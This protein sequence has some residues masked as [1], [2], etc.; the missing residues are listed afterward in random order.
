MNKIIVIVGPTGVGKTKLSVEIAKKYNAEII[1]GDAMQV[2]KDLNIGTAKIKEEEKEGIKHHLFNIKNVDED[3]SIYEYQKDV[4]QLIK[5]LQNKNKNI[6]IVGGTGLYIKS[7][8]YDYKLNEKKHDN[9]YNNMSKEELYQLLI[10]KDKDI[11]NNIDKNNKRRLVNA[12]NYYIDNNESISK[13]KTNKLLYDTIFIGLTTNRENLY[14]IINNRVDKMIK[15]GLINEVKSFYDKK[16]YTKP[17]LGGIGYKELY[18]YFNKEIT[19]EEAIELI[20]KNSRHYAKRQYTFFNNQ[21]KVT[22]FETD[23][24]NFNN[25]VNEV[26]KYIDKIIDKR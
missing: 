4:R 6:I 17:L 21:L 16:I 11:I 1:N 24:N 10:E 18:R 26:C 20:K 13:N 7:A 2:Y 8:L 9:K 15:E 23:Y 22:W 3:Y 14:N 25:T 5:K 19:K 12:I